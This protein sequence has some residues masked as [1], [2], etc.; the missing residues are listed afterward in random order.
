MNIK[1]QLLRL[2]LA[3]MAGLLLI[4]SL[5]AGCNLP[6]GQEA[7]ATPG[8]NPTQAYETALARV[9][10]LAA[11]TQAAV[12]AA[13]TPAPSPTQATATPTVAGTTVIPTS[14]FAASPTGGTPATNCDRAAANDATIDVTIPDNTVFAP[15]QKF[16]KVWRLQNSGTCTW[17]TEYAIVWFSGEKLATNQVVAVPAAV[18][19]G[20]YVDISVE[21]TAPN[22]PGT[23]Q[24]NWKFRNPKGFL[25]GIGPNADAAFWA[26]IVVQAPTGTS[27][28]TPSPTA[29]LAGATATPTPTFTPTPVVFASGQVSLLPNSALDLD[30]LSAGNADISYVV[31]AQN[32]HPIVPEAGVFLGVYG[33]TQPGR[34]ACVSAALGSAPVAV[35]VLPAGT[36]LCFKTAEGRYGWLQIIEVLP[37][38]FTLRL[39]VLTWANP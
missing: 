5:L 12:P 19:P 32:N 11:L 7:S 33:N 39:Q 28:T 21:M 14:I 6:A 25:F 15:G 27:T 36:Y 37:A 26:I 23:Y 18:A 20:Q 10:E 38:D 24:S 35:E 17:T 30:S 2:N 34:S 8:L 16:T 3:G 1:N 29:T 13:T 9:T 31:D 22:T 4:G